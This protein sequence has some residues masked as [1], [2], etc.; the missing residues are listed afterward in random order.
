MRYRD[1]EEDS[2]FQDR[3]SEEGGKHPNFD[4][5]LS[6]AKLYL[7]G[8]PHLTQCGVV[9]GGASTLLRCLRTIRTD[10]S[11]TVNFYFFLETRSDP[12]DVAVLYDLFI[13]I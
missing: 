8:E 5:A 11:P 1:V 7:E 4:E 13:E 12:D 3:V 2:N 9:G 6:A 10:V